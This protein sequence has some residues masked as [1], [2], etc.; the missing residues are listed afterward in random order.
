MVADA[1]G[2]M[3]GVD[4]IKSAFVN[5]DLGKIILSRNANPYPNVNQNIIWQ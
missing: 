3:A 5:D 4:S 1:S 2:G